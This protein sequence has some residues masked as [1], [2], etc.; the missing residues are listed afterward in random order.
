MVEKRIQRNQSKIESSKMI[1]SSM[2]PHVFIK[3]KFDLNKF[4][5]YNRAS[6]LEYKLKSIRISEKHSLK[7]SWIQGKNFSS[8]ICVGSCWKIIFHERRQLIWNKRET[9]VTV[10]LKGSSECFRKPSLDAK[11]SN[12]TPTT[13]QETEVNLSSALDA[14]FQPEKIKQEY[15]EVQESKR[16]Q[17]LKNLLKPR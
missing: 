2:C 4:I 10:K 7:I 12:R 15:H 3:T 14:V 8:Y 5:F 16:D 11:Y 1:S 13:R 6:L 9:N 17:R